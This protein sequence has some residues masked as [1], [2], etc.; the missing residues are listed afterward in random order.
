MRLLDVRYMRKG[1]I[2]GKREQVWQAECL[3]V[4]RAF[5]GPANFLGSGSVARPSAIGAGDVDVGQE[6]HVERDLPRAVA[7]SAA[8]A[9]CVVREIA[10]LQP[11]RFRGIG[12]RVCAAHIVERAAIRGDRRAHIDADGGGVDEVRAA[13]ALGLNRGDVLGKR[14]ACRRCGKRGNKCFEHERRF[15]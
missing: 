13:N 7:G 10:H 11:C 12:A 8:K 14:S 5:F 2:N 3:V 4:G 9:S 1:L 6:L 15:A